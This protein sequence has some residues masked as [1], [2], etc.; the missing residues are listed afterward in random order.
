[1]KFA[2]SGRVEDATVS[3]ARVNGTPAASCLTSMVSAAHVSPFSGNAQTIKTVLKV[4]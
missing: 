3:G 2:P 4:D 1:V